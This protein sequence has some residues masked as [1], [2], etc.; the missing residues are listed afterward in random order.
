MTA[1]E[2]L[3]QGLPVSHSAIKPR[4]IAP[5]VGRAAGRDLAVPPSGCH[6]LLWWFASTERA[7]RA[8]FPSRTARA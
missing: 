1:G 3:V 4:P 8:D 5:V 2:R 7:G 6:A